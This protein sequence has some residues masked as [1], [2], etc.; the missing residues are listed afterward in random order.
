M[1][2][3]GTAFVRSY[4]IMVCQEDCRN[5][6]VD[7]SRVLCDHCQSV[8]GCALESESK[9]CTF[10]VL[11]DKVRIS[12]GA[13]FYSPLRR[14][15]FMLMD[16]YRSK[17]VARFC[18][19]A[20]SKYFVVTL[21][22]P[23]AY[24]Q[25][26]DGTSTVRQSIHFSLSEERHQDDDCVPLPLYDIVSCL[27]ALKRASFVTHELIATNKNHFYLLLCPPC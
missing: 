7:G 15:L 25:R 4:S 11:K 21:D 14:I 10:D 20:K 12:Q 22:E 9:G 27:S 13:S 8:L 24:V 19:F 1:H 23:I 3:P 16:V 5:A 2:V 18:C 26:N 6:R 17:A